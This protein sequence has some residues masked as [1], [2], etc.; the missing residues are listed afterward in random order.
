MVWTAASEPL[1]ARLRIFGWF[2]TFNRRRLVCERKHSVRRGHISESGL[3]NAALS[4]QQ[5][6]YVWRGAQA[7]H[8]RACW[9]SAVVFAVRTMQLFGPTAADKTRQSSRSLSQLV[10]V[11]G[12]LYW[13]LKQS[14]W[15]LSD[16]TLD[17]LWSA[18]H[19]FVRHWSLVCICLAWHFSIYETNL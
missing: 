13:S 18:L 19:L 15:W 2:N 6:V 4:C 14:V 8:I 1:Y 11:I 10:F 17:S 16:Q 5:F 7:Q 3:K 9:S 12:L